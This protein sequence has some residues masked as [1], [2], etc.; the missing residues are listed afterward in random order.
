MT[1]SLRVNCDDV[2]FE[3]L[4]TSLRMVSYVDVVVKGELCRRRCE[5]LIMSTSLR[6]VSCVDVV[7]KGELCRRR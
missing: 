5:G 6:M 1:T 2:V 3:W 4:S 7:I